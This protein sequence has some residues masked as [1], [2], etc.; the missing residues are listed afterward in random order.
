MPKE[1]TKEYGSGMRM[2]MRRRIQ[3]IHEGQ[4]RSQERTGTREG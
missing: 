2:E 3:V 4:D 1:E